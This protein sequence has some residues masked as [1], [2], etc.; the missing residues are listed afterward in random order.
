MPVNKLTDRIDWEDVKV[1]VALTTHGSLSAAAR[2]LGI[3]HA[4]VSRRLTSLE[5]TLGHPLFGRKDGR[6]V[7]T[8]QGIRIAEIAARMGA[9]VD[10][11]AHEVANLPYH[12]T[13]P[14]H[15][16]ATES[17]ATYLLAPALAGVRLMH[18][19][20]DL[21]VLVTDTNLSLTRFEADLALRLSRPTDDAASYIKLGDLNYHLYASADYLERAGNGPFDYIGYPDAYKQ[22]MESISLDMLLNG[23]RIVLK[24]N[25][26]GLRISCIRHGM[27]VGLLPRPMGDAWPNLKRIGATEPIMKRE[28]CLLHLKEMEHVPR[29][30]ACIDV[31][32]TYFQTLP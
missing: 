13:G 10:A 25:Q 23:G 32:K 22:W 17:V 6:Y 31:L 30:R 15:F 1:F 4:T 16:T 18:P 7:L 26:L 28:I 8:Q 3:T 19:G 27:G 29:L 9:S 20:I 2:S 11:I 24:T 12:L 5:E 14:V 21:E